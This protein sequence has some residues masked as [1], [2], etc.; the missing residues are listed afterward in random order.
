MMIYFANAFGRENFSFITL[1]V[2]MGLI[3]I[4]SVLFCSLSKSRALIWKRK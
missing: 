1:F 3:N 4:L 2:I